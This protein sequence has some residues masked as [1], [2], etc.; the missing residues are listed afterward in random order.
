MSGSILYHKD[1]IQYGTINE[2]KDTIILYFIPLYNIIIRYTAH[3]FD[4]PNIRVKESLL[5]WAIWAII[6][7]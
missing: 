4:Q 2:E 6:S 1:A 3:Q 7:I 5:R